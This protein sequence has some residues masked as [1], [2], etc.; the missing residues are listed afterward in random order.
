[1]RTYLPLLLILFICAGCS[2]TSVK[3]HKTAGQA[4]SAVLSSPTPTSLNRDADGMLWIGTQHG[5]NIFDGH[6]Y[7]IFTHEANSES[8]LKGPVAVRMPAAI[9]WEKDV[10]EASLSFQRS[11]PHFRQGRPNVG[12][13]FA[14]H[15]REHRI[16]PVQVVSHKC[17][18]PQCTVP[19]PGC[20]RPHAGHLWQ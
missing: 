18:H 5:L 16:R 9:L 15:L 7:Q 6:S 20:S 13:H 3:P 19:V 1:M 2:H 10:P 14:G 17:F 8:S 4:F 11:E 12:M